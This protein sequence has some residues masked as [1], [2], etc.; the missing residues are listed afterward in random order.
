MNIM[1]DSQLKEKDLAGKTEIIIKLDY[2]TFP[3]FVEHWPSISKSFVPWT[4]TISISTKI[5]KLF[6]PNLFFLLFLF[7]LKIY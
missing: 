4:E 6:E 3:F 5:I 1:S 2:F 7:S